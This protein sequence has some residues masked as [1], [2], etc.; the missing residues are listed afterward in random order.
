MRRILAG[1]FFL[2]ATA[3]VTTGFAQGNPPPAGGAAP[4]PDQAQGMKQPVAYVER[5]LTLPKMTLS[6]ELDLAITHLDLGGF[7]GT[8]TVFFVELGA[9]FGIT[10]DFMVEAHPLG[11]EAGD[12]DTDYTRFEVGA[13]YRFLK[14]P[15]EI[16]G[17]FRFQVDNAG[18]LV[19]NPGLPVRIHGG[20]IVRIDTG[21]NFSGVVP[22]K[23]DTDSQA[24]LLGIGTDLL[25]SAEAGIPVNVA[26]QIVKPVFVGLS[27]GYGIVAFSQAG[28]TSFMPLGFFAGGTVPGDQG[29]L[30]DIGASFGFPYFL[31]G[32]SNSNPNTEIWSIGLTG[33][34]FLYL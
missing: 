20:E 19:F 22:T 24:A 5:P 27:T 9:A 26:F 12:V 21:V 18:T 8:A 31:L 2:A 11:I 16:G 32:G 6:P 34:G 13:T 30:L 3:I 15:V 4:A 25:L 29:P 10:D 17:R 23:K 14:G 7:L 1:T 33:R 28:D